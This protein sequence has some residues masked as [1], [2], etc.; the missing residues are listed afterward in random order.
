[1]S[2]QIK[3]DE[4]AEIVTN[5]LCQP[6]KVG[7]LVESSS[8]G[9]FM[10][11]IAE[12]VANHCGGEVAKPASQFEGVWYVGVTRTDSLPEESDGVWGPYDENGEL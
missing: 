11:T 12:A 3:P 4:L 7:E 1:M 5:L 6:E 2:K 10:T 9:D 8:Y